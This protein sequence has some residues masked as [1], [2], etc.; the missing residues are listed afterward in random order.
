M[1]RTKYFQTNDSNELLHLIM[2]IFRT[3]QDGLAI[4][5]PNGYVLL[6]NEAYLHLTGVPADVL[7]H[8]SYMQQIEMDIVTESTAVR[9]IQTKQ[10]YSTAIEYAN[11]KKTINTA[12]PVLDE[13]E[14]LLFVVGNIRDIT[15]LNLL[16]QQL[17]E[18]RQISFQY[19]KAL[20]QIQNDTENKQQLVYRSAVM[21]RIIGMA[22]RIAQNDSPILLLGE[23]GV[24]KDVIAQYIHRQ[25]GRDGDYVKINCGAI[26]DHL[27]ESELFGYEKGA[28]TGANQSKEGLLELADGGTI[29][30]DEIGDLPYSLQVKLL[31]VLQDGEIRRLG[32][33]EV[34]KVN[35]RVITA[36]NIDLETMV[37]QKKFR[38]D[39]FYRL[40]VLSLTIPPLRER[41]DD[42]PA[43]IFFY[44][45]KLEQRYGKAK[46]M[47]AEAIEALTNYDW[48]GNVRELKNVLERTYHMT[49]GSEITKE[50]LPAS[51]RMT[52][53]FPLVSLPPLSEEPLSLREAV[54]KFEQAY[55]G[56]MLANTKNMQ[57]CADLL[58]V[59]ISTLVRKKRK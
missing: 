19:Q 27:L 43:L 8:Y 49:E 31:N 25:S 12:T 34:K 11:G 42:I 7:N 30:L 38:Q 5:D 2:T 51:A 39:L 13:N 6:Y 37:E 22:D 59:N 29:F 21:H 50:L 18:A 46:R 16:Q 15:Q 35:M 52:R 9:A 14:E 33:K 54:R 28:F 3:S 41:R 17:E 47:D 10:V 26:P 44:L 23:S 20:E 36:T 24:G 45:K 32:A 53:S 55:I 1:Y 57:E 4:C 58:G 48:P 56:R 40:N